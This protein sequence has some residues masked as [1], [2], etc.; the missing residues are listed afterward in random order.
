MKRPA[1]TITFGFAVAVLLARLANITDA[2]VVQAMAFLIGL[3]PAAVTYVVE[4]RAA[5]RRGDPT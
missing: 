4:R 1:E 2:A 3:V 5:S